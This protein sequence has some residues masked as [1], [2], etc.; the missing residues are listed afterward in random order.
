MNKFILILLIIIFASIA[1]GEYYVDML[2]Y[3]NNP[4]L[5]VRVDDKLYTKE[6]KDLSQEKI[7]KWIDNTIRKHYNTYKD[8]LYVK[9]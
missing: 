4:I 9:E 2:N 5:E 6:I 7:N 8:K 1:R 3:T